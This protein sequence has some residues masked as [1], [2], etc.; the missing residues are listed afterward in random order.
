MRVL[1]IAPHADDEI[2]GPGGMI[3]RRVS[4][5]HEVF[6][7]IVTRGI[8][9]LFSDEYMRNLRF[10]TLRC[11]ER[12]GIKD[13]YFLEFPSVMLEKENRNEI[14]AGISDVIQTVCPEE[15]FLPHLGDLQKD[16]QI[17]AESAMVAL[18]PK[19]KHVVKRAYAYETL[20]ET[21]WNM[22]NI[23]NA[24]MPNVYMDI[25]G[26]LQDKLDA[27]GAYKSQLSDFPSARSIQAIEALAKF[28]GASI[29]VKAA[30]A[31]MLIREIK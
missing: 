27:L 4:E 13:H 23:Q 31:F 17:V 1:V 28:R 10:E 24:F 9:P 29:N 16:H 22:P 12:I 26:Y 15:V 7:C 11:H 6:V 21:G 25:S 19:Y 18:R 8:E 5:G 20:S 30:E 14:N 3:A 2:I